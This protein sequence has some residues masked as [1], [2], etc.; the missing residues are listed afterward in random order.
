[1]ANFPS[2][3]MFFGM[4]PCGSLEHSIGEH[5]ENGMAWLLSERNHSVVFED[6]RP[7]TTAWPFLSCALGSSFE[8][9]VH[10]FLQTYVLLMIQSAHSY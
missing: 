8:L 1:M 9:E 5:T 2:R 7:S 4:D 3:R 10:F 6:E